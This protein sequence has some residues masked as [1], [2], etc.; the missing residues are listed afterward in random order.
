MN[1]I[2]E[3]IAAQLDLEFTDDEIKRAIDENSNYFVIIAGNKFM[4]SEDGKKK[5]HDQRLSEFMAIVNQYIEKF[6]L[7]QNVTE[8]TGLINKFLYSCLG[9]NI[10]GL[11]NVLKGDTGTVIDE[12]DLSSFNNE[13][14]RIVNDFIDWDNLQKNELLFELISFAVDYCRLTVKKDEHSFSSILQGKKFFLDANIFIRMMGVDNEDRQAIVN[15]FVQ[16]CQDA[17]I[18][19][20]Y[21]SLTRH[22]VLDT[23]KYHV[24]QIQAS[25][26]GYHG[27]GRGLQKAFE[28][29]QY[30]DGFADEYLKWC[31]ENDM[32]GHYDDFCIDLEKRFYACTSGIKLIEVGDISYSD[33]D[34]NS[35]IEAK[36]GRISVENAII[37]IRNVR[38]VNGLRNRS[39]E[40]IAWN[41]KEYII[42]ADHR[43]VDWASAH[44]SKCNPIVVL[45]SVWYSTILK[46]TG[47]TLH[48]DERSFAEFIK[49]RYTQERNA[50][51][52]KHLIKVV[53]EKTDNGVIQDRLLTALTENED[54]M[55]SLNDSKLETLQEFVNTEYDDILE[56]TRAEG[57]SAGKSS[58]HGEGFD[59]GKRAGRKE[60][61]TI[62]KKIGMIQSDIDRL[63][64]QPAEKAKRK[65]WRNLLFI[66]VWVC[67][68]VGLI[69][70]ATKNNWHDK[71]NEIYEKYTVWV[72]T[73]PSAIIVL[74]VHHFLPLDIEKLKTQ[75]EIEI[76]PQIKELKHQLKIYEDESKDKNEDDN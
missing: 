1:S 6:N 17:H 28:Q 65:R 75:A 68:Y 24:R 73:I 61:L 45:P 7:T 42:S 34:I 50:E 56:Q 30:Q 66:V 72:Y 48:D 49:M 62:G 23:I 59:S 71:I 47:R 74:I 69:L 46:I 37:D 27:T 55:A 14:R 8:I 15:R 21:T 25:F 4:L 18:Q 29:T 10:I 52:L 33:N 53:T 36:A 20:C 2:R 32:W 5:I 39:N 11:L 3:R 40:T 76:E 16:K 54:A 58:G 51:S 64:K 31:S 57:F 12:L 13:Q 22:E 43:L 38:F 26:E 9:R 67:L 44:V 35:Y 63:E 19:L 70:I 60:G 41:T